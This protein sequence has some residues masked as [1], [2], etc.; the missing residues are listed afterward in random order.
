MKQVMKIGLIAAASIASLSTFAVAQTWKPMTDKELGLTVSLPSQPQAS[1]R[2]DKDGKVTIKTKIWISSLV[3]SN[4]VVSV[5]I[6]PPK[7][8]AAA[9]KKMVDDVKMG[10]LNSVGASAKSDKTA[11]Y[12][13]ISGREVTF[14]AANG[15]RGA[16][17]VVLRGG[18]MITLT[19]A[20]KAGSYAADQKR[21]F[22]S[23][24]LKP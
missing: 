15:A 11:V 5:S 4:Y 13:G 19:L 3:D 6:L 8:P 24:R 9:A 20:K 10:F 23:L 2:T 22:S 1:Q 18:K 7:M 16:L 17:W 12:A 21:F 14:E